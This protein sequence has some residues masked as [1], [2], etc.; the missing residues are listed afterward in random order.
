M[1]ARKVKLGKAIKLKEAPWLDY[2]ERMWNWIT[3]LAQREADRWFREQSR[4][5]WARFY[6]YYK[7]STKTRPGDI[8]VA[9]HAPGPGWKLATGQA[10]GR[11]TGRFWT[12]EEALRWILKTIGTIPI[13]PAGPWYLRTPD[14]KRLKVV[15]VNKRNL[16]CADEEG[17][18]RLI[19]RSSLVRLVPGMSAKAVA[20]RYWFGP[21]AAKRLATKGHTGWRKRD[22]A[23]NRRRTMIRAHNGDIL[24][25]ARACQALANVTRDPETKRKARADAKYLFRLYK[26]KKK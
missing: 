7:P 17:N 25:A 16:V 4:N 12:R 11:G 21:V 1:A 5:P 15:S 6:L 2:P 3:K 24:A 8:R 19:K 22:P 9:P 23:E 10:L 18:W 14:G 13:L 20:D 26:R